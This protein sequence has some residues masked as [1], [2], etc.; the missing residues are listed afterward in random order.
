MIRLKNILGFICIALLANSAAADGFQTHASIHDV[1][2]KFMLD[3]IKSTYSQKADIKPGNLDSRLKLRKCALPLEASLPNGSRGIGKITVAVKCS[4]RKPWSLHVP[5]SVS[6]L[7]SVLVAKEPLPRGKLLVK[8][9]LQQVKYDLARLPNGY[10]SKFENSVGMKL[11]RPLA[12]G[13]ALTPNMIEKPRLI[14]R[15]QRVTIL[16]QSGNMVVRSSGKALAN[17]AVGERIGVVNIKSKRKLEGVVTASG[18]VK[19]AI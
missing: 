12:T 9:D 6:L 18:E 4:D 8:S 16:A 10:I 17:G 5:V 3:H 1:A 14:T 19:V 11:K 13:V 7:K 2:R 15:G